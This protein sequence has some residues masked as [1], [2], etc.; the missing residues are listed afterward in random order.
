MKLNKFEQKSILITSFFLI[1]VVS[2]VSFINQNTITNNYENS[3]PSQEKTD[4]RCKNFDKVTKEFENYF[5]SEKLIN[6]N[7]SKNNQD[8][9]IRVLKDKPLLNIPALKYIS[10]ELE[11]KQ[12]NSLMVD[13]EK[14]I[15]PKILKVGLVPEFTYQNFNSIYIQ[16]S[17]FGSKYLIELPTN[18]KSDVISRTISIS[19]TEL[20]ESL[21][22]IYNNVLNDYKENNFIK[23]ESLSDKALLLTINDSNSISGYRVIYDLSDQKPEIIYKGQEEINC[24]ILENRKIGKG[25]SCLK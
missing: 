6:F 18:A 8:F 14:N 21:L 15:K 7:E 23:F 24:Q 3:N 13:Y 10:Q 5:T 9:Y 17:Q 2:I 16:Y 20:N 22:S 12:I 25:L 4:S 11:E 1:L 19:C